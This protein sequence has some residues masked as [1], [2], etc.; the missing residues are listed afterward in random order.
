[1]DG[2]GEYYAKW[3]KPGGER[4]ILYDLTYKWS[5]INETIKR[6]ITRDIEIQNKLTVTRVEGS[7]EGNN[8]GKK[9]KGNQGTS[10]KG[11]WTKSKGGKIEGGE[12]GVDGAG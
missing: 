5:L 3:N 12:E 2:T 10:K 8:R 9:G 11:P 4:Q 1:M 6:N 7:E